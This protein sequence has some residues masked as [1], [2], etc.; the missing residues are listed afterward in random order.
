MSNN[1]D[2]QTKQIDINIPGDNNTFVANAGTVN[3]SGSANVVLVGEEL[4]KQ[5]L[6]LFGDIQISLE[7]SRLLEEF[8]NDYDNIVLECVKTDFTVPWVRIGLSD[9]ITFTYS[10]KWEIRSLKFKNKDLRKLVFDT[11]STLSEL[12][13]YLTDQY[14]RAV[15]TPCGYALIAR[16]ESWE[17]GC[18]LREVLRPN[19]NRLRY[20]LRDLYRELHPEAYGGMPPFEDHYEEE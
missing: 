7:D 11:L 10:E 3:I 8:K 6:I 5:E 1:N 15:D 18:Q 2:V 14:M 19:T 20:K 17:Q 12:S 13:G 16:N 9:D 4:A